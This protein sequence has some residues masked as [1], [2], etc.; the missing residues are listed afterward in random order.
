MIAPIAYSWPNGGPYQ[1]FDCPNLISLVQI[2]TD[3]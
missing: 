3:R 1:K 2:Y